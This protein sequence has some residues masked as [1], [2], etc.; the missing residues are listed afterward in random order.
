MEAGIHPLGQRRIQTGA[1][2]D[3]MTDMHQIA[4]TAPVEIMKFIALKVNRIKGI[5]SVCYV[6]FDC[7]DDLMLGGF[8]FGCIARFERADAPSVGAVIAFS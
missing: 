6:T 4:G 1:K 2:S 7:H 3:R 8:V 5:T